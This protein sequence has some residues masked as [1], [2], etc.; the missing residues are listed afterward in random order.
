MLQPGPDA[1]AVTSAPAAPDDEVFRWI[2]GRLAGAP[3]YATLGVRLVHAEPGHVVCSM[4]VAALHCNVDGILHG[5]ISG[6]LAD[7]ALGFAVRT[8]ASDRA[9]NATLQAQMTYHRPGRVGDTLRASARVTERAG[10]MVY[11]ECTITNSGDETLAR[12]T[13]LNLLREPDPAPD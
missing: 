6:L 9:T 1:A 8:T 2:E 3:L 4:D 5:G 11:A 7:T 12:G 13:S 10:R